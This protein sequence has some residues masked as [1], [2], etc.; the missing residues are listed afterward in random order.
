MLVFFFHCPRASVIG[1][2]SVL[3]GLHCCYC[4]FLLENGE[5]TKKH[6]RNKQS[7]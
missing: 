5:I 7:R 1:L 2:S 6:G 3:L 4:F